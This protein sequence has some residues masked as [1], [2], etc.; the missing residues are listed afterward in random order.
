MRFVGLFMVAGLIGFSNGVEGE[1]QVSD[2]GQG[3][4]WVTGGID[5]EVPPNAIRDSIG[6]GLPLCRGNRSSNTNGWQDIGV[7]KD[8]RLCHTLRNRWKEEDSYEYLVL[9]PEG[10]MSTAGMVPETEVQAPTEEAIKDAIIAL[11]AQIERDG[12]EHYLNKQFDICHKYTD[13]ESMIQANYRCRAEF[14]R[15]ALREAISTAQDNY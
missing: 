7:R 11:T 5:S 1:N 15:S 6:E 14:I 13:F 10:G 2:G 4:E 3:V 9:N 8:D 12:R